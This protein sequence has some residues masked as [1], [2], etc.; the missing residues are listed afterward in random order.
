MSE[1][2]DFLRNALILQ[3]ISYAPQ[4]LEYDLSLQS[5][6]LLGKWLDRGKFIW[7]LKYRIFEI[8]RKFDIYHSL[9]HFGTLL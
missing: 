4:D 8:L 1:D 7:S 5:T 2:T 3:M 6:T 9:V